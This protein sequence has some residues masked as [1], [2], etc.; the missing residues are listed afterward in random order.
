MKSTTIAVDLSKSVFEIAI[1][2]HPGKVRERARLTR[3][4][5]AP[6]FAELQPA[7][8]LMEACGSAH[9]WGRRFRELGHRV[10]LIPP[11]AT[12]PYV[13]RNK[14]DRTDAKALLEAY[15][16]KDIKP[17]PVKSVD[18][19]SIASL[20]RLRSGWI[21]TRTARLNAL[22]GIL[23][24]FGFTIPL[25]A[26]NVLPHVEALL[27]NESI[28]SM[29]APSL[30]EA[31]TEIRTIENRIEKL[32]RQLAALGRD[33]PAIRRLMTIPGIGLLT[34]TGLFAIV[35]D[36]RR[37]PSGRHFASF[38]GLTPG[39]RSSG[40]RRVLTGINK[41][42]DRYLRMLLIHGAR[43]V[44]AAFSKKPRRDRLSA[45]TL[46]L[47]SRRGHNKAVVALANKIAR[48]AWAVWNRDTD[49]QSEPPTLH[50]EHVTSCRTIQEA[51]IA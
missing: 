26:R 8:V 47:R 7:T 38:L 51:T 30:A 9:H 21:A 29:L 34:A 20:H 40:P 4:K 3:A 41:K 5:L 44:L 43:A 16:N 42:G 15:R 14:T 24:E 28:S 39:E 12:R 1:S 10:V 18:Q 19:Q 27:E 13:T 17:V 25:G 36:A 50:R 33:V 48:R 32:E 37:F 22:R 46:E 11:H 6:F 49:F 2:E 31:C 23:R 35:G 45:W